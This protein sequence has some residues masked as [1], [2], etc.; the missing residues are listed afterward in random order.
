MKFN[1]RNTESL[2]L[3]VGKA[4]KIYFDDD[5]PGF[6][7]RLR[8]GGGRYWIFQYTI[9]TKR[10]GSKPTHH[11]ISLGKFSAVP[12]AKARE[13]AG[14]YYAKVRLGQ[15]PA[16]EKHRDRARASKTFEAVAKL[17]L[18]RQRERVRPSSYSE[19]ERHL[20]VNCKPL[21]THSFDA[22]ER[23]VIAQRLT[24]ITQAHGPIASN[25]VRT[26]LSALFSWAMRDGWVESNPAAATN[27]NDENTRDRVLS[28]AELHSLWNALPPGD[29]GAIVKLL[30]LTGQRKTEISDLCWSEIDLE[31]S[32]IRL[33]AE[34]VKNGRVHEIPISG[35]VRQILETQIRR[36]ERDFVFGEG[37]GGFSGFGRCKQRLDAKIE[38]PPWTLHDLRRTA[39]TGM[40]E[41]GVQPHIIEA[42]LNHI[43]GHKS[44]VAGIY[45]RA[46]YEAEKATALAR[47]AD[48]VT[49]IVEGRDSNVTPLRRG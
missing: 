15:N 13:Q 47:W 28:A 40:A 12:V 43:S 27:R 26:T 19:A 37:Q 33:P 32:F 2:K 8:E 49:N 18:A 23:R 24:E 9:G 7:L 34:R 5:I 25:R 45:N 21:H 30:V 44:G 36:G 3:P 39:A 31:R 11:R 1:V 14:E 38:L 4:E 22:I 10:S 41:I 29:F 6:G 35:A 20:L 17:F 16:A 42:V 46:S 48:H